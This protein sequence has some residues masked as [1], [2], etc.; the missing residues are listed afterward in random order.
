M[1]CDYA[2]IHRHCVSCASVVLGERAICA[3]HGAGEGDGWHLNN[4][5]ACAFIHR[6]IVAPRLPEAE[7]GESAELSS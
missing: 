7:R 4:A 1:L 6:Q 5:A 3:H 2:P